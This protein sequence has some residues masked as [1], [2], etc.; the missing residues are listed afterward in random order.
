MRAQQDDIMQ[1]KNIFCIFINTVFLWTKVQLIMW[2][3]CCVLWWLRSKHVL[4]TGEFQITLWWTN[5]VTT[6]L[7]I[8][9]LKDPSPI[10]LFLFNCQLSAFINTDCDLSAIS[11]YWSGS[12]T[13]AYP[14]AFQVLLW[15]FSNST[16]K[17]QKYFVCTQA[18]INA[19]S[20]HDLKL[21]NIKVKS[22]GSAGIEKN[23]C[24]CPSLGGHTHPKEQW[25]ADSYV[26]G[27]CGNVTHC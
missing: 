20:H 14:S 18:C 9:W 1:F 11:S 8:T 21:Q 15:L 13:R 4:P 7:L 5:C 16:Y 6:T 22:R 25:F 23:P 24:V 26:I 10:C 27:F 19:R 3:N 17:L 2:V 12:Y